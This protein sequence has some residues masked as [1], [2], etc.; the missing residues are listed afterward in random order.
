MEAPAVPPHPYYCH[1]CGKHAPFQ[2]AFCAITHSPG[3]PRAGEDAIEVYYRA[4][5]YVQDVGEA[6]S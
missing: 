2:E 3:C 1:E 4:L 6:I 5:A